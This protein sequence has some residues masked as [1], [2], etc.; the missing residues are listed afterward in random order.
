MKSLSGI[1][2]V[3]I[4]AVKRPGDSGETEAE[5]V[6]RALGELRAL[7]VKSLLAVGTYEGAHEIAICA[8]PGNDDTREK[9]SALAFVK[10]L[11]DSVLHLGTLQKND[12]REAVLEYSLV[13]DNGDLRPMPDCLE[14]LGYWRA[15]DAI[16]AEYAP[17]ST[18]VPSLEQHYI[19]D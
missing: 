19:A 4:F 8:F 16:E 15:V 12:T 10:Y 17:G 7:G 3:L 2:D 5:N 11:Q 14:R 9:V 13:N 6:R 1:N 18:F